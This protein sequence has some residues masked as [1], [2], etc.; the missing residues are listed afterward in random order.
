MVGIALQ[1]QPQLWPLASSEWVQ[2]QEQACWGP[3]KPQNQVRMKLKMFRTGELTAPSADFL[4]RA[5]LGNDTASWDDLL[6]TG[7]S[8]IIGVIYL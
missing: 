2:S 3:T 4:V 1:P 6:T 7:Q 8:G 5:G